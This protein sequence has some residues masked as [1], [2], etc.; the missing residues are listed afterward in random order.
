ME[1]AYRDRD[2]LIKSISETVL[3]SRDVLTGVYREN[4]KRMGDW[5]YTVDDTPKTKKIPTKSA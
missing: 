1:K 3:A 4:M 2:L 5:G